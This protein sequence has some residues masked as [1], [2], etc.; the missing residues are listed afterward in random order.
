MSLHLSGFVLM[1]LLGWTLPEKLFH[2]RDHSDVEMS[3]SHL[4]ELITDSDSAQVS[5]RNTP[6][7][8]TFTAASHEDQLQLKRKPSDLS[9]ILFYR[10]VKGFVVKHSSTPHRTFL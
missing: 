4:A 1:A 2:S 6:H 7:L 10:L 9:N 3:S 5:Q 8:D